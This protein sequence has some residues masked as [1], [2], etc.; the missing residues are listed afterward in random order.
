MAGTIVSAQRGKNNIGWGH[1]LHVLGYTWLDSVV[2]CTSPYNGER[3]VGT[4]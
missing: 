3:R 2:M 4:F 1:A